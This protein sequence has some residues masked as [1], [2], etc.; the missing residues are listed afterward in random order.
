M[1]RPRAP[2]ARILRQ[3]LKLCPGPADT[4]CTGGRH[5]TSP[6]P[7]NQGSPTMR[8]AIERVAPAIL[9]LEIGYVAIIALRFALTL[10]G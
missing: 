4:W 5:E 10:A 9:A 2:A 3:V 7:T 8:Q 6:V 1:T